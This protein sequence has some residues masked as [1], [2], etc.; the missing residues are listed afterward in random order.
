MTLAIRKRV[1]K[2]MHIVMSDRPVQSFRPRNPHKWLALVAR[3]AKERTVSDENSF[4]DQSV[5]SRLVDDIG[6]ENFRQLLV[7]LNNEF[8]KRINNIRKGRYEGSFAILAAEVHAL[9]SSAQIS[10]AFKLA[11]LLVELELKATNN[12]HD[13][14]ALAS[15]ALTLADLTRLAFLDI[16]VD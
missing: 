1:I 14:L 2:V 16:K 4:V 3:L 11:N 6:L 7:S 12:N 13:A 5:I 9:K 8:Q 15:E 10:G